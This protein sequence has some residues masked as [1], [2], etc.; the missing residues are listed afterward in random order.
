MRRVHR[1]GPIVNKITFYL[2]CSVALCALCFAVPSANAQSYNVSLTGGGGGQCTGTG[3]GTLAISGDTLEFLGNVGGAGGCYFGTNGYLSGPSTC[4]SAS[5][6][7]S[8]SSLDALIAGALYTFSSS[9]AHP[10][11]AGA[12]KD[13]THC[14]TPANTLNFVLIIPS[15]GFDSASTTNLNLGSEGGNGNTFHV[16]FD[17]PVLTPEPSSY[18]L[19]GSAFLILGVFYRRKFV[20]SRAA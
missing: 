7:A 18:L 6:G 19:F 20:L 16:G 13:A 10:D 17:D 1:K 2:I 9:A 8:C 11:N 3:T 4:T 15:A 5:S 14:S 12:C